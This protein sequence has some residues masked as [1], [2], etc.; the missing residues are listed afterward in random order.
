MST[1]YLL[2]TIQRA[3]KGSMSK[4][5]AGTL[6]DDTVV[7]TAAIQAVGG[8]LWPSTDL[9]IAS[10]AALAKKAHARGADENELN[11]IMMS[12][13]DLLQQNQAAVLS[14]T[15]IRTMR[16][17]FVKCVVPANV[18]S[19]AAFPV[20]AGAND[21]V[22][23]VQGDIVLLIN[24]TTAKQNGP[25]VV[26]P[27]VAGNAPLTRPSW[28]AAGLR[29]SPAFEFI[30]QYGG[31][32]YGLTKFYIAS[33]GVDGLGCVIDTTASDPQFIPASLIGTVT[34]NGASPSVGTATFTAWCLAGFGAVADITNQ[35]NPVGTLKAVLAG[36][37]AT[38]A[39]LTVTGPN[40]CTDV[41]GY[42]V[43]NLQT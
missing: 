13:V 37:G 40:G 9:T 23:C 20:A 26:G 6:V 14:D 33:L 8:V 39:T 4:L 10:F 19:L 41:I 1:Y 25:Y 31:T 29:A 24:Q 30:V 12:G 21:G 3:T 28:W 43:K 7:D 22:A 11:A 38:G 5:L 27:V 18:A 35:T 42:I 17:A 36:G 2:N 34:M 15:T 16:R 32:L